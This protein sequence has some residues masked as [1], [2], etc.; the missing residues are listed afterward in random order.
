MQRFDSSLFISQSYINNDGSQLYLILQLLYYALKRL[1][2]AEKVVS[3]KSKGLSVEKR[4]AP[5]TT[6][7]SLS[8]LIKW[9]KNSNF[10]LTFKEG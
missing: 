4:T 1:G 9:C 3:W 6:E 10:Y 5:T 2:D 8:P 7:N